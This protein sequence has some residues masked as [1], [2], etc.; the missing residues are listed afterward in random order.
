MRNFLNGDKI[1]FS[2]V[3]YLVS[4]TISSIVRDV[5]SSLTVVIR[6]MQTVSNWPINS[7]LKETKRTLPSSKQ[8][9]SDPYPN[10]NIP[11]R[12]L[13]RPFLQDLCQRKN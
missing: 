6:E 3:I 11:L 13:N 1:C 7:A 2:T 8:L 5:L 12:T 10:H 4:R 9:F